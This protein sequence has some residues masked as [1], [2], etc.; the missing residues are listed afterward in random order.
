ML[1]LPDSLMCLAFCLCSALNESSVQEGIHT[2]KAY[3]C[4]LSVSCENNEAKKMPFF[5]HA[6]KKL[7]TA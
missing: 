6:E 2:G 7:D 5:S 1:V 4:V 3:G